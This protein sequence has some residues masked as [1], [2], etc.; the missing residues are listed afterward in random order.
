MKRICV[1]LLAL[2]IFLGIGSAQVLAGE[3]TFGG[4]VH[5]HWLL[6]LNDHGQGK[7]FNYF[8]VHRG[9]LIVDHQF[10]EKYQA[11]FVLEATARGGQEFSTNY[12]AH[13]RSAYVQ[14]NAV[15]KYFD[16]RF[17]MH[18]VIWIDQVEKLWGLR[19]VDEV[20]LH[21]LG[22]LPRA[23]LGFSIIG[24]CPGSW[25]VLALQVMNG[26]G[27]TESEENKYKDFA[28]F[29][30][31]IPFPKSPDWS[32]VAFMGQYYSGKPN[33][34]DGSGGRSFSDNTLKTRMQVA[35][36]FKYRKWV[37][38]FGEYFVAKDDAN[39][40]NGT[41]DEF[42]DEAQG[43]T[44][45]GRMYVATSEKWL[46]R[47]SVFGKYEWV[48]KNKNAQGLLADLGDLRYLTAGVAYEPTENFEL[49]LAIRRD[50]VNEIENDIRIAEIESN[51]FLITVKAFMK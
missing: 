9:W 22:Y 2:A 12:D 41:E 50:T 15:F 20:S 27:Y 49:A 13:I 40:N 7:N 3:T 24:T 46:S 38:A 5:A 43:Y 26:A 34:A 1:G 35:G 6:H 8:N 30:K 37:T 33:V 21:K 10:S 42:V 17:G 4:E 16:L 32:E 48:D 44:L 31:L 39:W 51:S 47:V 18:D 19:Y 14:A 45:F 11:N 23:D 29:A 25:G 36:V 28:M